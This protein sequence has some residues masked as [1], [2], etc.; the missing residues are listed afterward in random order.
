MPFANIGEE[1]PDLSVEAVKRDLLN[2][3]FRKIA[4]SEAQ[5]HPAQKECSSSECLS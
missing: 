1:A 2:E 3:E 5:M 4:L